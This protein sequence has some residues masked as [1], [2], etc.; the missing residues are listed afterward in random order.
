MTCENCTYAVAL[1]AAL[2]DA[3][4]R[5]EGARG[6]AGGICET[7]HLRAVL[8]KNEPS[9]EDVL[10]E[11]DNQMADAVNAPRVPVG[12]LIVPEGMKRVATIV[13]GPNGEERVERGPECVYRDGCRVGMNCQLEERCCA[14]DIE[15]KL[16]GTPEE[17]AAHKASEP[18]P[19]GVARDQANQDHVICPN[20]VH[21]FP[22]VPVNVQLDLNA[23]RDMAERLLAQHLDRLA[24]TSDNIGN[25]RR[26]LF[27]PFHGECRWNG[28]V[29]ELTAER[30]NKP[31][32][33]EEVRVEPPVGT[34][35]ATLAR[36]LRAAN[37]ASALKTADEVADL[38]DSWA[39]AVP[40]GVGF[41]LV[42]RTFVP[43]L[44]TYCGKPCIDSYYA[45]S[46]AE[47]TK[48]WHTAPGS[49]SLAPACPSPATD[50]NSEMKP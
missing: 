20:C 16:L 26:S 11:R 27:H 19:V 40:E 22:A 39:E 49:N 43:P 8:A 4:E 21:Q 32:Q 3:C 34:A 5:L 6:M 9:V 1:Q 31:V 29:R 38:L 35:F 10:I 17:I 14:R 50:T 44:C 36:R 37:P 47:G 15:A 18:V 25:I 33:G 45:I 24:I 2:K 7:S 30:E 12:G 13:Y 23:F 46:N 42:A 48:V 28:M 41:G